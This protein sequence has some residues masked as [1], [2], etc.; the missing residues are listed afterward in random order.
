MSLLTCDHTSPE[1]ILYTNTTAKIYLG[2][3]IQQDFPGS[4]RTEVWITSTQYNHNNWW[5]PYKSRSKTWF[6]LFVWLKA[7]ADCKSFKGTG[8]FLWAAA[9]QTF[10]TATN[11]DPSFFSTMPSCGDQKLKVMR[12]SE[13]EAATTAQVLVC[14]FVCFWRSAKIKQKP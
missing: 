1:L 4:P 6:F 7:N 12:Q 13:E 10:L 8:S 3:T 11:Q 9:D 14:L 5:S 2:I